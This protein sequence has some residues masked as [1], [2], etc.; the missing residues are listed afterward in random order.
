VGRTARR[1]DLA[2]QIDWV[3]GADQRAAVAAAKQAAAKKP[4]T[5]RR[6]RG[7]APPAA[8]IAVTTGDH[9][10][11]R[12]RSVAM[13]VDRWMT[14]SAKSL[15]LVLLLSLSCGGGGGNKGP[16]GVPRS[17][18]VASLDATQSAVLCDWINASVGGYGASTTATEAARA[19][20]I[21]PAELR[22]GAERLQRLSVGDRG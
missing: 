13:N 4:A 17:A 6:G 11:A 15:A 21:Q 12:R 10:R 20:R 5:G 19:T 8:A 14:S 2:E 16:A 9:A 22:L 3:K 1:K 7:K 18:T